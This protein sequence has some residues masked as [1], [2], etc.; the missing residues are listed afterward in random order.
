MAAAGNTYLASFEKNPDTGERQIGPLRY[1]QLD[2]RALT[3]GLPYNVAVYAISG[4]AAVYGETVLSGKDLKKRVYKDLDLPDEFR[5]AC[6]MSCVGT[7]DAKYLAQMSETMTRAEAMGG[8]D[9]SLPANTGDLHD[10]IAEHHKEAALEFDCP[11]IWTSAGVPTKWSL[12]ADAGNDPIF[13]DDLSLIRE[14]G[15]INRFQDVLSSLVSYH[16]AASDGQ[17]KKIPDPTRDEA[18]VGG[19]FCSFACIPAEGAFSGTGHPS[20]RG[21]SNWFANL[22]NCSSIMLCKVQG[23]NSSCDVFYTR[24]GLPPFWDKSPYIRYKSDLKRA[25]DQGLAD[26]APVPFLSAS[27][28]EKI[29]TLPTETARVSHKLDLKWQGEWLPIGC[30]E[31]VKHDVPQGLDRSQI[32]HRTRGTWPFFAGQ[33]CRMKLG[34]S[35]NNMRYEAGMILMDYDRLYVMSSLW[36][37]DVHFVPKDRVVVCKHWLLESSTRWLADF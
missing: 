12:K 17:L 33:I 6:V 28:H 1:G 14:K 22:L 20:Q 25:R 27:R 23:N 19:S 36:N 37:N 9:F 13:L 31:I 2:L 34:Y 15:S 30:K 4:L 16:I 21:L 3:K 35:K 10:R 11:F 29:E 26:P 18:E 8:G 5:F 24:G 32:T 7:N